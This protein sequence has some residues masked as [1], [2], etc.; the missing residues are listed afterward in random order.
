M[1]NSCVVSFD[2]IFKGSEDNATNGSENWSLSTIPLLIDAS[3]CE[4]RGEYPH[5]P[6]VTRNYSLWRV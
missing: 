6:Y 2:L 3:S 5:K 1:L 4:N